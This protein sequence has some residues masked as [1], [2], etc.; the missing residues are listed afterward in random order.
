MKLT[1]R[2][3]LAFSAVVAV[4]AIATIVTGASLRSLSTDDQRVSE[5]HK[6]IVAV[7]EVQMA[8]SRQE[9]L[10]TAYIATAEKKYI[11]EF[12]GQ[13]LDNL[14]H[15]LDVAR[16]LLKQSPEAFGA[17]RKFD[18][19]TKQWLDS[20][21]KSAHIMAM[22]DET[23]DLH[24][25][26]GDQGRKVIGMLNDVIGRL[27][28]A[29]QEAQ[30]LVSVTALSGSLASALVAAV[31]CIWLLQTLQKPMRDLTGV[32]ESFGA[33]RLETEIPYIKRLDEIGTI[34]RSLNV[35]RDALLERGVLK[36]ASAADKTRIQQQERLIGQVRSFETTVRGVLD[37]VNSQIQAMYSISHT[38]T[39]VAEELT[40]RLSN[41]VS[42]SQQ[43]NQN[44]G[45]I[46]GAVNELANSI[47]A[48]ALQVQTLNATFE[49]AEQI[50]QQATRR[51]SDLT[52]ASQKIGEVIT[53]IRT[54]AGQ[55]NLLALNATIEAS[56]AGEAGKG[57]A[58]V[59]V[60][61]KALASQ[62]AK[63]TDE[64]VRHIEGI[65]IST[66][67]TAEII[68]QIT[69]VVGL[70]NHATTEIAGAVRQLDTSTSD[71]N[72]SMH[73]AAAGTLHVDTNLATVSG[74][75]DRTSQAAADTK[76]ASSNVALQT[77]A[78]RD[79]ISRFLKEVAA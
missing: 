15:A 39:E 13:A 7:Y 22:R 62:T 66:S 79:V 34:A 47:S 17:F 9:S 67:G 21:R 10:F 65:Q 16:G 29:K 48:I 49:R 59:A 43:T 2:L 69:E 73:Q 27:S 74:V 45:A 38:L 58:V 26:I 37:H 46:S 36:Q 68:G 8:L 41:A 1:W 18:D 78:L 28:T 3:V 60:E 52:M 32:V 14:N 63:A 25:E 75:A 40:G 54:I 70:V 12:E 5:A 30:Q 56:R 77:E 24:A 35:F 31:M 4:A 76:S 50:T 61:V 57:F 51:V 23:R 44:V 42:A 19:L 55:T 53:M 72:S 20:A 64:I 33:G 11:D 6:A 71:I